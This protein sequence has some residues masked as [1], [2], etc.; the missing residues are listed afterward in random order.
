MLQNEAVNR[1]S[2][3]VAQF[4]YWPALASRSGRRDR[5]PIFKNLSIQPEP[6]APHSGLLLFVCLCVCGCC[7]VVAHNAND[8]LIIHLSPIKGKRG[9]CFRKGSSSSSYLNPS[10]AAATARADV[11][12]YSFWRSDESR[13]PFLWPLFRTYGRKVLISR[14][15]AASKHKGKIHAIPDR[16]EFGVVTR[17]AGQGFACRC[18]G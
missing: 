11:G 1:N 10:D 2:W 4:I 17:S 8:G 9:V 7:R 15:C 16:F 3:H 13:K 12:A 5:G 14:S 18:I 6:R